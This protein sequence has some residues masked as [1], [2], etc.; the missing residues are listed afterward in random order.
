MGWLDL[1]LLLPIAAW[2]VYALVRGRQKR[3]GCS[4]CCASC[5]AHCGK[6]RKQEKAEPSENV[7]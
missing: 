1:L 7:K 5:A 2:L 3:S 6:C 4:G